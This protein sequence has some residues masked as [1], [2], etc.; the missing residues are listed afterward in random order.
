[1]VMQ[2]SNKDKTELDMLGRFKQ[3]LL[4]DPVVPG[5]L[6]LTQHASAFCAYLRKSF[7]WIASHFLGLQISRCT[8]LFF[9]K[10]AL[11][12]S[13]DF[14][15]WRPGGDSVERRRRLQKAKFISVTYV[16]KYIE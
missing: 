6:N 1:M 14:E 2:P 15:A 9:Y 8:V 11:W 7:P 12:S 16:A 4:M 3:G 10:V 5:T 13:C